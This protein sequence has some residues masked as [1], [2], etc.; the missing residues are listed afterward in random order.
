M[1]IHVYKTIQPKLD[2]FHFNTEAEV[3]GSNPASPTKI[4]MRCRIIVYTVEN[5]RVE[6]ET[7]PKGIKC[8]GRRAQLLTVRVCIVTYGTSTVCI[9]TGTYF[10]A[11][12]RQQMSLSQLF[13]LCNNSIL[14]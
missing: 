12:L 14:A 7:Y 5:L 3:P 13:S 10:P 8:I 2:H 6:R 4:L 1:T 11:V 9:V